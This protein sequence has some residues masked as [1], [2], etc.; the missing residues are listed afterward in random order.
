[1]KWRAQ[2]SYFKIRWISVHPQKHQKGNTYLSSSG[3]LSSFIVMLIDMF[4]WVCAGYTHSCHCLISPGHL[5]CF[6]GHQD[7]YMKPC[8]LYGFSYLVKKKQ[9]ITIYCLKN[10]LLLTGLWEWEQFFRMAFKVSTKHNIP[11]M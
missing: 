1:M 2:S 8:V 10:Y 7:D 4:S 11:C 5:E 3:V 6:T 9:N